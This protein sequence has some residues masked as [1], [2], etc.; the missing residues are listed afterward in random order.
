MSKSPSRVVVLLGILCALVRCGS[1]PE[2]NSGSSGGTAAC[3]PGLVCAPDL[4][5]GGG[6]TASGGSDQGTGGSLDLQ[7][8]GGNQ[9]AMGGGCNGSDACAPLSDGGPLCGDGQLAGNEFCDDGNNKPG[10]GCSGLCTVEPGYLCSTPGKLCKSTVVCGDGKQ[11][12][13]EGCDDGN[14]KSNDGCSATCEI[15]DGYGCQS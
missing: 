7:L 10:D 8:D 4:D 3:L 2:L 5:A 14:T 6:S 11:Q 1:N 9:G 12:G 15:E 13:S